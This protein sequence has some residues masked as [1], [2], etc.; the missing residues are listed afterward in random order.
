M[1]QVNWEGKQD[2][3][4]WTG[5][6]MPCTVGRD[7]STTGREQGR[8]VAPAELGSGDVMVSVNKDSYAVLSLPDQ[9][10]WRVE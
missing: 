8:W 3:G 4:H 10:I 7:G 1:L 5:R 9:T 2:I 6:R